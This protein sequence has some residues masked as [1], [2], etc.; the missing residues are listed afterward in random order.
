MLWQFETFRTREAIS[1]IFFKQGQEY[2]GKN[3]KEKGE[4]K[5]EEGRG[6]ERRGEEK[7]M[8]VGDNRAGEEEGRH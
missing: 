3:G 1:F 5:E 2:P 8:G 7:Q 6:R 4:V